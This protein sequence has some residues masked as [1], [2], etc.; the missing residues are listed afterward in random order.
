MTY[1]DVLTGNFRAARARSGLGM[2]AVAARMRALG[3]SS[4]R[5]QTV[6]VVESGDR[7]LKAE[8]IP[9]L[10]EVMGTTIFT[11]MKPPDDLAE[12]QLRSGARIPARS[13]ALSAAAH[14][15]GAVTWDG[16]EPRFA[17][18][19]GDVSVRIIVTPRFPEPPQPPEA[20]R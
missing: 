9:A 17:A 14:D 18:E 11:L 13:I 1:A 16:S 15:D 19:S 10:A 5:Y 6:G 12:I 8:E 7:A 4:W 3:F 20:R 2:E